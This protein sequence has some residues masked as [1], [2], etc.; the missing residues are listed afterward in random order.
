LDVVGQGVYSTLCQT[1]EKLK[2]FNENK[3]ERIHY[4]S[5]DTKSAKV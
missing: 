2:K 4:I 1:K 3:E 5:L